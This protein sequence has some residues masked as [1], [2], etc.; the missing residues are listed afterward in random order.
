MIRWCGLIPLVAGVAVLCAGKLPLSGH[1][2]INFTPSIPRGVYWI[3]AGVRPQR[4]ALVTF[5][6]PD[7]VR[8]FVYDR[9]YVPRTIRLLAKP[10]A[11]IGGDHVCV[12]DHQLVVN[13]HVVGNVL[14]VDHDGKPMPQ[15]TGCGLLRPGELFVAT[16]HDNSFDSRYF[17]PLELSV[18]RGTLSA[19]ITF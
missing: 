16:P 13:G 3:S 18:V 19:L 12:R 10:V 15:Y 17:G 5:P 1:L 6:I 2:L 7:S 8:E 14:S 4:G 9:E 11:A